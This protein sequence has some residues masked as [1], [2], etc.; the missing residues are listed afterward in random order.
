M[1]STRPA[2]NRAPAASGDLL[3]RAQQQARLGTL[4]QGR[5]E[6]LVDCSE[7]TL[8]LFGLPARPRHVPLQRLRDAVLPDDQPVFDALLAGQAARPCA[9]YRIRRPD[10]SVR[11]LRG[12]SCAHCD[13]TG[14]PLARAAVVMDVTEQ[15]LTHRQ[16]ADCLAFT[17]MATGLARLGAWTI[18]L[19]ERTLTW[20]DEN[21]A[22]HDAPAGYRPTLREGLNLF[23]PQH[24]EEVVRLVRRC[25]TEGTP[26]E[27][28]LPKFTMTGRRIWVRSIGE[29]V[30]D[31]SGRIVRLQGAFQDVTAL[32]EAERTVRESSEQLR[33]AQRL[34]SIG[35]LTGGVA[36]DF[37]N[38]LTV[39]LGNAE[40]LREELA[41]HGPLQPL[42]QAVVEAAERGAALTQRLL[43]FARKQP[44]APD[45][46]DVNARIAGLVP[47]VERTLGKHVEIDFSP[48]DALWPALVDPVQLDNTV[49]NLCLNARDAMPQ[50]G[51]LR[52]ETSGLQLR[53]GDL[54]PDGDVRPGP[55][56][57]LCVSD[58]GCGIDPGHL[59]RVF[60]PFFSTKDKAKGT[61]LGLPMVYGFAKQSGGHV[62]IESAVG[63]GTTVKLY[64][65]RAGEE[66]PG[67]EPAPALHPQA[68]DPA[69]RG[70]RILVVDDEAMVRRQ[71]CVQLSVLGYRVLEASDAAEALDILARGDAVDLL[72]TDLVMP[73][74]NGRELQA[75]AQQLRPGL[76]VLLT[77]G[78]SEDLAAPAGTATRTAERLLPK[79]YRRA[80]L[81]AF[82]S[83]ALAEP[84]AASIPSQA[85]EPGE[86]W[87]T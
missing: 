81:A 63:R 84:G 13:D 36:H 68:T 82:V 21:C 42:A 20:S 60:E 12:W 29:A 83:R 58:T 47:L 27:F 1:T 14:R 75:R 3:L 74:L 77:S 25:E 61:G 40:I 31:G 79:P 34:E 80:E 59:G 4:S 44:L 7:A 49:L 67:Q 76:P 43:A 28:E 46:V 19:P 51:R 15:E 72:F 53:P 69:G 55:Y 85:R 8:A 16:L 56:V 38:L 17:R 52:I 73:G 48:G 10:G 86:P 2:R 65:P 71:A 70:Q 66:A 22:I 18:D 45:V 9:D 24:R 39:I 64:L 87:T 37:N 30:R 32:K 57:L 33:Q 35:Q 26:Y 78:Y 50:G 41:G 11:W 54:P 5:P 23:E 62:L 6:G